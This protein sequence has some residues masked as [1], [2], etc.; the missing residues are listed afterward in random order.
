MPRGAQAVACVLLALG[1]GCSRKADR[2]SSF[3]RPQFSVTPPGTWVAKGTVSD[4]LELWSEGDQEQLIVSVFRFDRPQPREA[5][6]QLGE[7]IVGHLAEAVQHTSKGQITWAADKGHWSE[8]SF[9][10]RA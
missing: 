7:R 10:L 1:A 8:D 9:E 5:L 6:A 3:H 4:G 2:P